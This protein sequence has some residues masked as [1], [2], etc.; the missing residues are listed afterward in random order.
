MNR[1]FVCLSTLANLSLWVTFALGLR[2]GDPG[3]LSDTARNQVSAHFLFALAA[4]MFALLVHAIV[5]TY[6][7]GTG[8]WIE[9]TSA[10]YRFDG[11]AREENIRLKYRVLPAMGLCLLMLIVTGAFGAV[12]DPASNTRWDH[13]A[14]THFLLAV[15]TLTLN[16]F[17]SLVEY[18]QIVRN[19]QLV[20]LVY[21][22]V[23]AVRR[24]RKLDES[25]P[26]AV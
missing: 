18:R 4:V 8:R 20:Q 15:G 1:I 13:A 5:L 2:I 7:M 22:E 26:S 16:A 24:E 12:A 21:D 9:E 25:V 11:A 14:I 6:F 17:V 23:K 19:G 3:S 10:A